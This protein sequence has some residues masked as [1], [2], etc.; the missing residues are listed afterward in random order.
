[1]KIPFIK[2]PEITLTLYTY[3]KSKENFL[4]KLQIKKNCQKI[5]SLPLI[6][7]TFNQSPVVCTIIINQKTSEIALKL[8]YLSHMDLKAYKKALIM[9]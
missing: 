2:Y 6:S 1:M 9:K 5:K 3:L 7:F 8:P 4:M